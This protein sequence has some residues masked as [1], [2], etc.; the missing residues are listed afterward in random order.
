MKKALCFWLS[1]AFSFAALA[2]ENP[3]GE[4]AAY[5]LNNSSSRSSWIIKD[6][7]AD[8]KVLNYDANNSAG[9]GYIMEINYDLTVR[10]KGHQQ[11]TIKLF[12]PEQVFAANFI[13]ELA[14]HHPLSFGSFDL[15][16]HGVANAKDANDRN[17]NSCAKT[18][19]F[20]IDPNYVPHMSFHKAQFLSHKMINV[21]DYGNRIKGLEIEDLEVN[22]K[23]HDSV[24][25]LGA[26]QLDVSGTSSGVSFKAGFDYKP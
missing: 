17:Y 5:T 19:I 7:K 12:V 11:G 20:N 9:P 13:S 18:R 2:I 24:P 14:A 15:D 23:V 6:G 26:V 3:V 16:Y 8:A 4:K 22:L 21:D 1:I 10:F 25:V